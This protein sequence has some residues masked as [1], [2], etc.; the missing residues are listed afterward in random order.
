MMQCTSPDSSFVACCVALEKVFGTFK[1]FIVYFMRMKSGVNALS[2]R[3]AVLM[4]C[5]DVSSVLQAF[6]QGG[7]EAANKAGNEAARKAADAA[8]EVIKNG[9]NSAAA[10]EA[11]RQ[12]MQ[13]ANQV[14]PCGAA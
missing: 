14:R 7:Q 10:A 13:G 12:T 1:A 11:A 6:K 3:P 4:C 5:C 2:R 9:G 8:A